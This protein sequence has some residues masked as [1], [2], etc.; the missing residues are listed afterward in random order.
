M[1]PWVGLAFV[2]TR[3]WFDGRA[4]RALLTMSATEAAVLC[5]SSPG[6]RS[7]AWSMTLVRAH[8]KGDCAFRLLAELGRSA[9]PAV[10]WFGADLCI[11]AE[12]AG[13]R[14]RFRL[15]SLEKRIVQ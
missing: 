14:G 11:P 1:T 2:S 15:Q 7:E 9:V 12:V 4:L 8:Q 6:W 13:I 10:Q 5:C 3:S